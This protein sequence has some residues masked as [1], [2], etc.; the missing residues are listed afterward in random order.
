MYQPVQPPSYG[1]PG[2]AYSP[3]MA[4]VPDLDEFEN[5]PPL[6]EELGMFVS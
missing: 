4:T 2:Y 6:L 3:P 1:N 5:E